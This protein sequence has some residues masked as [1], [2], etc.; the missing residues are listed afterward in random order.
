[1]V[2]ELKVYGLRGYYKKNLCGQSNISEFLPRENGERIFLSPETIER[3]GPGA[4]SYLS[5]VLRLQ[6]LPASLERHMI[7]VLQKAD[8]PDGFGRAI[9]AIQ[10]SSEEFVWQCADFLVRVS[11]L[12]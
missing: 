4:G 7:L 9:S 2:A 3:L 8:Q 6:R 10:V 5:D 11:R 12:A 1:M